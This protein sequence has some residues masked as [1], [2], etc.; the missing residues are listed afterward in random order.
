M[1]GSHPSAPRRRPHEGGYARGEETRER[2][3]QAAFLVFAEEGYVG[4]STRR[5]AAEAGVNPPAL[6]YYFDSKE[7]LHRACGQFIVDQVM[8]QIAPALDRARAASA[9][10]PKEAVEALCELI[11]GVAV[12]TIAKAQSDGWSRFLGRC[13]TDDIGPA[14]D[15]VERGIAGPLKS[16]TIDLVAHALALDPA[17]PE[18]RLRAMLILSQLN[19]LHTKRDSTLATIGWAAFSSETID[20]VKRVFSD[21]V[22]R[23][24]AGADASLPPS[25]L[26]RAS[27]HKSKNI[28]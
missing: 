11:E 9:R 6:Q 22:R 15:V 14:S 18:T 8:M 21:H 28:S 13:E 27:A 1:D 3:I 26:W 7:G 19:A 20:V 25:P 24:V 16:A 12:V 10:E 2:I 23:L 17:A 5:I 4:A